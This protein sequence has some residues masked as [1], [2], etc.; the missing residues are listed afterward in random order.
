MS[1]V[2]LGGGVSAQLLRAMDEL[3]RGLRSDLRDR[4]EQEAHA[5]LREGL[6]E[7]Q[8]LREKAEA[9]ENGALINGALTATAG[10]GQV[11]IG[12]FMKTP[13]ASASPG[14]LAAV[15]G[16]NNRLGTVGQGVGQLAPIGK[17]SQDSHAARG[18]RHEANAREHGARAA[19]STR[20]ADAARS[21]AQEAKQLSEK[22]RDLYQQIQELEHASRMAV[23]RG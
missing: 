23:L 15:Q 18:T 14:Q 19:A 10:L 9:E 1:S 6:A 21:D 20:L 16:R 17:I 3:S 4:A 2:S 12:G 5:A 11:A 13:D 8:E 22:G 7:A